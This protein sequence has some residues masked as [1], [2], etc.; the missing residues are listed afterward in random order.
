MKIYTKVKKP[1]DGE[2]WYYCPPAT[3]NH[4]HQGRTPP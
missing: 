2:Y 1:S 4:P 3:H